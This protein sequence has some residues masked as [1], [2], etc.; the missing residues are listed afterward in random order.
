MMGWWLAVFLVLLL[1]ALWF[2]RSG[3]LQGSLPFES[4]VIVSAGDHSAFTSLVEWQG[5]L[6]LVY[7]SAPTHFASRHSCLVVLSSTDG[8]AW[9]EWARLRSPGHDIR[10]PKLA[11]IGGHLFLYA[12]LN[13]SFDPLPFATFFASSTDGKN[14]AP[15]QRIDQEGWL[16][17]C[18]KSADGIQWYAAAHWYKYSRVALFSS[19]DG[20]HWRRIT[21][22]HEQ[23]GVDETALEFLAGDKLLA[24]TRFDPE[25]SIFGSDRAGTLLATAKAPFTDW[26]L[27]ALAADVR[28]DGP[29]L[30]R[31]GGRLYALGR[32]QPV[33]K[34]PFWKLGSIF[35]ARRTALFLVSRVGLTHI[36]DLPSAGDTSYPGAA[37]HAG[38]W[39]FS[40]YSSRPDRDYS[41]IL[42]M[43]L[44]T[45][46]RAAWVDLAEL[47]AQKSSIRSIE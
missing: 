43:L 17:G 33:R 23:H 39:I 46:I 32:H 47:A 25:G 38:K 27:N 41:W 9:H 22:I 37:F 13:A 14:W 4:Q 28:L 34:R 5:R 29:A 26:V 44:P 31:S 18:P 40:Y 19:T 6:F 45:C 42:G 20:I 30:F 16:F 8:K 15:F 3:R 12:L 2:R 24:V 35:S 11:V 7:V 21:V 1:I 10:D 36:Q